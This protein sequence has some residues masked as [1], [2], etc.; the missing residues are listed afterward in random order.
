[1]PASSAVGV[2]HELRID[3]VVMRRQQPTDAIGI[4]AGLLVSSEGHDQVASRLETLLFQAY[5][6]RP[7]WP[8][9]APSCR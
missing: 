9:P 3:E 1:M 6:R 5:Q 8:H 7:P 2:D 4:A